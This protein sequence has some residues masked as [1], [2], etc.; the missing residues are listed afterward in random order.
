VRVLVQVLF[1]AV[2]NLPVEPSR[3]W[4]E[5][6]VVEVSDPLQVERVSDEI[7][8]IVQKTLEPY[9]QEGGGRGAA[10]A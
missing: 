5:S 10:G 3:H 1:R 4:D 2:V 7:R 8:R 9:I 6:A